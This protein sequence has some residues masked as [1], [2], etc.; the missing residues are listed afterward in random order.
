MGRGSLDVCSMTIPKCVVVMVI[1]HCS[2]AQ[3]E[4]GPGNGARPVVF[5]ARSTKGVHT[6]H[7]LSVCSLLERTLTPTHPRVHS[8]TGILFVACLNTSVLLSCCLCL[9]D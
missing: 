2:D 1:S 7:T 9:V 8:N 5:V 6:G 4:H 3:L